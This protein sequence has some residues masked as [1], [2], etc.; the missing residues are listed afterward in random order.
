MRFLH[1]SDW[2]L[3]MT[4]HF[5]AGEAQARFAADRLEALGA[6]LEL[7]AAERCEAVVVAGDVFETNQVERQTVLRALDTL[8]RSRVPV[9]LL[10]G[11]HDPLDAASVYRSRAFLENRPERVQVLDS[12]EPRVLASG[13]EIVGV[14]W[15]SLR[16]LQDLVAA[17]LAGLEPAGLPR[18]VVAHGA[19]DRLAAM[20]RENPALIGL[21]G[22]EAAIEAGKLQ[23]LALGDRHSV[24][25]VGRT[26]RVWYS[27]TPEATDFDEQEPG[28]VLLVEAD[29]SSCAV[30]RRRVGRWTFGRECFDLAAAHDLER[31]GE[32]L[33]AFPDKRRSVVK[34][35]FRG[36]L[37]LAERDALDRMLD[38]M[39]ERF[40][41]LLDWERMNALVVRP[42]ADDLAGAAL[43]GHALKAA[44]RLRERAVAG[45]EAALG[46][47]SLLLRLAR[48][49]S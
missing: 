39:R 29:A 10:P 34:V 45:D 7:A 41:A 9:F 12:T 23:Y 13:A 47:L 48:R 18:V 30:E 2:Q 3:G 35:G 6:L 49:D 40:A 8:A 32:W 44:G 4:R 15:S 42:A 36:T 46:A 17:A 27:G 38:G 19:V 37:S 5:L 33:A 31:T 28:Q 21:A 24:T 43:S 14:P 16:P 1:T 20:D 22:V 26:G 25:A 11:N